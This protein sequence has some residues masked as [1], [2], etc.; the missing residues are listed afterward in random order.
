MVFSLEAM[1]SLLASVSLILAAASFSSST[2]P[3]LARL[4]EYQ[5]LND[6]LEVKEKVGLTDDYVASSGFCLKLVEDS[7]TIFLPSECNRE[8]PYE[9]VSTTRIIRT[10]GGFAMLNATLW[11]R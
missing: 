2:P 7:R 3:S 8:Q 4:Y 11:R 9:P 6:F 10:G 5:V 1:L